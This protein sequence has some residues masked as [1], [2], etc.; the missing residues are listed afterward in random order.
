MRHDSTLINVVKIFYSIDSKKQRE[1]KRI[2]DV[3]RTEH[4]I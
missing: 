3:C 1:K 4:T 2:D